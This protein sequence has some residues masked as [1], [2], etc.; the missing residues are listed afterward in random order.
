MTRVLKKQI[1]GKAEQTERKDRPYLGG[2][3]ER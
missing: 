1:V 2:Q 3:D